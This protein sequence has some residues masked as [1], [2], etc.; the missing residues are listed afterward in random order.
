MGSKNNRKKKKNTIINSPKPKIDESNEISNE[1]NKVKSLFLFHNEELLNF[2]PPIF[3]HFKNLNSN[4]ND[5]DFNARYYI[6][7][8]KDINDAFYI[9]FL[10]YGKGIVIFKYYYE[11]EMFEIINTIKINV[12]F[13]E[14]IMIGIIYNEFDKKE[15]LFVEKGPDNLFIYLI[16]NEKNY[17]LINKDECEDNNIDLDLDLVGGRDSFS[18]LK[19]IKD[20]NLFEVIYN[21]FDKNIYIITVYDIGY[22][23]GDFRHYNSKEFSIKIFKE[24]KSI[25]YKLN[26]SGYD[27]DEYSSELNDLIYEDKNSNKYYILSFIEKNYRMIEIKEY[28]SNETID[29][30]LIS[31]IKCIVNSEKDIKTIEDFFDQNF[32]YFNAKIFYQN[33]ATYLYISRAKEDISEIIVIDLFKRTIIKQFKLNIEIQTFEYWG[34]KYLIILSNNSIYIFDLYT[35]Q[36]IT[37]YSNIII[38]DYIYRIKTY[39]SK[40]NNFY[41]LLISSVFKFTLMYK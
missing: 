32:F 9:S 13:E 8:L 22:Q 1:N 7:K 36:I 19:D 39:F 14:D 29:I 33:N 5:Y 27:D 41:G 38:E 30:E 28:N 18:R 3:K 35:C 15:Y 37:K 6:Y 10:M 2:P 12:S 16:N 21:Q 25:S 34:L 17:E 24:N 26:Y 11:K 40:K 4:N 23:K 31:D 20:I